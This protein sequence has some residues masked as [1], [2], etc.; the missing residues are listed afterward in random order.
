MI[1]FIRVTSGLIAVWGLMAVGGTID[2]TLL[3]R[4]GKILHGLLWI[5][6]AAM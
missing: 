6:G 2:P 5:A 1:A 3:G 4:A